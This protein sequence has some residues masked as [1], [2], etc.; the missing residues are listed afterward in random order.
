[1][2]VIVTV[3]PPLV[4]PVAGVKLVIVGVGATNLYFEGEIAVPAVVVTVTVTVPATCGFVTAFTV[5]GD[6]MVKLA[7]AVESKCTD[8]VVYNPVPVMVTVVPPLV[9]PVS[10]LRVVTVGTGAT[11][12]KFVPDVTVPPGVVT[13]TVTVPATCG[14]VT[15]LIVVAL[16]TV[17]LVGVVVPNLTEEVN[18]DPLKFEPV[19]VTLV[20]PLV[21][22]V[23]GEMEE[24]VGAGGTNLYEPLAVAVPPAVVTFTD[25]VP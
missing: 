22:P 3:V 9:V 1:V 18:P 14:F 13:L 15:A 23:L 7:A 16:V 20:P 12:L 25:T 8:V 4:V 2:P 19:M 6:V 10:G 21:V 17:K 24:I 11:Y 5:V